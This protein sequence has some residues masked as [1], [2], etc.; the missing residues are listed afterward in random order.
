M[1]LSTEFIG[2]FQSLYAVTSATIGGSTGTPAS[3]ATY[4]LEV[5]VTGG[6][7]F[8]V[9][10]EGSVS[11]STWFILGSAVTSAGLTFFTNMQ[12]PFIRAHCTALSGGT[13]PTVSAWISAIR[14]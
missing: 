3:L 7:T 9:Q 6:P 12:C 4:A 14:P 10:L 8:S 5:D 2:S 11:G 1:S 13:N